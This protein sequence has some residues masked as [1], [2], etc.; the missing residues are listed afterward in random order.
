MEGCGI[1]HASE[2]EG[3][4]DLVEDCGIEH[5]SESECCEDLV[6]LA[7]QPVKRESETVDERNFVVGYYRGRLQLP[8]QP[9]GERKAC[10]VVNIKG[11]GNA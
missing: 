3:C 9:E 2:F 4:E 11:A 10:E 7:I 8:R 5:A 1:E 6:G